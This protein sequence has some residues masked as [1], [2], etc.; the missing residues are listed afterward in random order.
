M[1]DPL[2]TRSSSGGVFARFPAVFDRLEAARALVLLEAEAG[3]VSVLVGVVRRRA[4]AGRRD[5]VRRLREEADEDE[6]YG[7]VEGRESECAGWPW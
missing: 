5:G 6:Q 3:L 1:W 2:A 7:H 4:A